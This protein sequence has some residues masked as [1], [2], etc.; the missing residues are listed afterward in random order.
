MYA[1]ELSPALMFSRSVCGDISGN[2]TNQ[3]STLEE[4]KFEGQGETIKKTMHR[5]CCSMLPGGEC[6][7]QGRQRRRP[8]SSVWPRRCA[9][10]KASGRRRWLGEVRAGT[11]WWSI[12]DRGRSAYTDPEV[13]ASRM[14]KG[15]EEGGHGMSAE[16]EEEVTSETCEQG[17][18]REGGFL[19]S[20]WGPWKVLSRGEG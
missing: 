14:V 12:P 8:E 13:E 1:I 3:I 16:E 9:Q 17:P 6:C 20:E 4:P 5:K 2:K 18:W 10:S 19:G 15:G 11:R 7:G